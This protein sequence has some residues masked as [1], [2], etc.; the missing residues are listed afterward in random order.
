MRKTIQFFSLL[1]QKKISYVPAPVYVLSEYATNPDAHFT[2][3]PYGSAP[4]TPPQRP[5]EHKTRSLLLYIVCAFALALFVRLF[6]AAPYL[7]QGASMD[8]TFADMHYLVIDRV[9][10]RFGEPERGD[11]VVFKFPQDT[12]RT[13][14]KRVIGLPGE[15]IVLSGTAIT[16]KNTERPDG[17]ALEE[18]YVADALQSSSN[19]T[20]TLAEGEYF[21]LGDNRRESADSRYWGALP[22]EDI[23]GRVFARLFPVQSIGLFPGE[24]RYQGE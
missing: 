11:V 1:L 12:S 14:I 5:Q 10:Y 9:S 6:I 13:F 17:F 16:I 15:T 20:V 23:V 24:A 18:P 22:R 21:V 3:E 8:P 7:V 19:M 4:Q 2:R